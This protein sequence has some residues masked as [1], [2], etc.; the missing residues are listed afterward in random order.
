MMV[1]EVSSKNSQQVPFIE[2]DEMIKAVATDRSDHSFDVRKLPWRTACGHHLL[3]T[4]VLDPLLEELAVDGVT[5][6]DH[7]S[8]GMI[9]GKRF[10]DLLSR[11][12]GCR[13][14]YAVEVSNT[15]SI[16]SQHHEGEEYP[17]RRCRNGE[18]IDGDN[19][20]DVVIQEG[21]P[22]LRRW[23][24]MADLVLVHSS[25]RQLVAKESEF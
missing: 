17:E 13:M 12:L 5:V 21:P 3:D 10:D 19:V 23:L 7:K 18:E 11:P 20:T 25:L 4:N 16:V 8:R 24:V 15:T 14:R 1:A 2:N 22:H 9:L 6:A